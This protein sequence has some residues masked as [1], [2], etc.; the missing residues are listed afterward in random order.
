MRALHNPM[1]APPGGF[2]Y[3][4]PE[5]GYH[6]RNVMQLDAVVDRAYQH[7]SANR[8]D[9]PTNLKEL[10]QDYVCHERPG[11]WC[12]ED[13]VTFPET[14]I[15]GDDSPTT[16]EKL[17]VATR[18]IARHIL[19]GRHTVSQ[20]EA[21]RRS[22]ICVGCPKNKPIEGCRPCNSSAMEAAIAYIVGSKGTPNDARLLGCVACGC[23][24]RA[25]V[26]VKHEHIVTGMTETQRARYW[27][28][29]WVLQ[30]AQNG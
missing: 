26:W 1:K 10:I 6:I 4:I 9:H 13:G 29:C 30:E 22:E 23:H 12:H 20:A 14:P 15:A 7:Y 11:P 8:I 19:H 16:M 21:N 18:S 25:K 2:S 28:N 5:T 24:L 17:V 27:V 3:V